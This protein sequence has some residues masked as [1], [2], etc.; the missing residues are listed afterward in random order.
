[1]DFKKVEFPS[2]PQIQN[3]GPKEL[4][5]LKSTLPESFILQMRRI[6]RMM[7]IIAIGPIPW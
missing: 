3:M 6:S 1:V 2:S 7:E 4:N 5:Q